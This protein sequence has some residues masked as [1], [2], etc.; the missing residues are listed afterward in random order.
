MKPIPHPLKTVLAAFV[1]LA[2]AQGAAAQDVIPL[3]KAQK[4]ARMVNDAAGSI[5]DAAVAVEADR[6]QPFA[7]KGGEV[8]MMIIPDKALTAGKLSAAGEAIT[9]VG[10][11]WT[12]AAIVAVSGRAP[13]KDKLRFF[14]IK[15]GE[16]ERKV[17]LYL[18]GAAK[19][20]QGTLELIVFGTDKEP[21]LRVPLGKSA[22]SLTQQLPIELSGRKNDE[23]S[24]TLTL[25][26]FG[27]YQA[28]LLL[29][30]PE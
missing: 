14:T 10:Q 27:Q 12:A 30:K 25:R 3:E 15:D 17:Q 7:I 20:A 19:N 28:D 21:L 5:G 26:L 8:A 11:L 4:A 24:G 23:D 2:L 16:E 22:E 29:V 1:T 6:D 13:A 9:P 18:V